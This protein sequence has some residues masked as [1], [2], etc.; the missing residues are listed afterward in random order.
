MNKSYDPCTVVASTTHL[1]GRKEVLELT[2]FGP[3]DLVELMAVAAKKQ[4][5][6]WD[7]VVAPPTRVTKQRAREE[8]LRMLLRE[9]A[10]LLH[11]FSEDR[12]Q[13]DPDV[14]E[15]ESLIYRIG[16]AVS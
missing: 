3:Y 6:F 8:R 12:L 7:F 1:D 14:A 9:A 4:S 13:D 15:A 11:H 10:D 16:K 5:S 2:I